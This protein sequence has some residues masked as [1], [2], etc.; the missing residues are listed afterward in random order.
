M[1]WGS[2]TFPHSEAMTVPETDRRLRAQGRK[3]KK[4]RS[5][6]IVGLEVTP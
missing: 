3:S 4:K 5:L 1:A 6:Q 2:P